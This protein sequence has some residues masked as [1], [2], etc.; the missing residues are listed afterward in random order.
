MGS[1]M[2]HLIRFQF[3]RPEARLERGLLVISVDVDVGNRELARINGGR[4][5]KNV[6]KYLSEYYVGTLEEIA[7][8]LFL[9][10]FDQFETPVTF[11]CRGQWFEFPNIALDRMLESSTKHD[12]GTHGFTHRG[13]V[14]LSPEEANTEL[15]MI[16]AAIKNHRIVPRSFIFPRNYIMHKEIVAKYGFKCYRGQGNLLKD[17][18]YIRQDGC[19][20]DVH[21]SL[22][23][24]KYTP[25]S[26]AKYILDICIEKRVPFHIWFHLWSHGTS[27]RP[28][29]KMLNNFFAPFL[30]YA[31]LRVKNGELGIETMSSAVQIVENES[32]STNERP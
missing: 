15:K 31:N 13:F 27:A 12:I 8:P 1:Q 23:I 22:Y 11:G 19:L 20:W 21:P 25:F 24:D 26:L 3:D 4:N 5:D 10:L 6:N 9:D 17:G 7:L 18:L 29:Q 14:D 16:L 2:G 28:I 32:L 30:H